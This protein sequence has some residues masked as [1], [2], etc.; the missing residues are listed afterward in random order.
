MS[1]CVV[2]LE[3]DGAVAQGQVERRETG[4]DAPTRG[5]AQ[6]RRRRMALRAAALRA[7]ALRAAALAAEDRRAADRRAA[8]RRAA[9]LRA[10]A[11]LAAEDLRADALAAEDRRA[12]GRRAADRRAAAHRALAA[13]AAEFADFVDVRRAAPCALSRGAS[14]AARRERAPL[15]LLLAPLFLAS[16]VC[17]RA[18]LRE[19]RVVG[20]AAVARGLLHAALLGHVGGVRD[21]RPSSPRDEAL[22]RGLR[23]RMV[24]IRDARRAS[25]STRE[26]ARQRPGSIAWTHRRRRGPVSRAESHV[27]GDG[28]RWR[29]MAPPHGTT[30]HGS[31]NPGVPK[32]YPAFTAKD[33]SGRK[34]SLGVFHGA[35]TVLSQ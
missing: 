10:L 34:F 4:S 27:L 15:A 2:E 28:A 16:E 17:V 23:K 31:R 26:T 6:H 13:L 12:A 3:V 14:S 32:A 22:P 8:G 20:D 25:V 35:F 7:A 29:K 5:I 21:R 19:L 9:A 1:L 30:R 33:A 18:R 11:A 24:G